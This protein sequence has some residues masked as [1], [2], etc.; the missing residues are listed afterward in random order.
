MI[1]HLHKLIFLLPLL[2]LGT[3]CSNLPQVPETTTVEDTALPEYKL[4]LATSKAALFK[5]LS[6]ENILFSDETYPSPFA[7]KAPSDKGAEVSD[8]EDAEQSESASGENLWQRISS[9]YV[10]LP[11]QDKEKFADTLDAYKKYRRYFSDFSKNASPYLHHIVESLEN[12]G[13]PLE[14]ALLP[15]VESAFRP[16][17]RSPYQAEGIWQFI[18]STG[19]MFGLKQ[20]GWY[21]GRRDVMA[22]TD[23]ALDYLEVLHKNLDN[24]WLNA[25]AAYNCGEGNVRRAIN[26]NVAEGKPTDYWSLDLP[27]E[28][29][30]YIPK[31]MAL[32]TIIAKADDYGIS[33]EEIP[34][35]PY[36]STVDVGEQ[37]DLKLAAQLADLPLQELRRLNPGF[38]H[39]VTDP[40]GP[41]SLVLPMDRIE[42][43]RVRLANVDNK[44]PNGQP[45]L[46]S[47][48]E[49][50]GN[51][52][53]SEPK[54]QLKPYKIR[55][56]DNLA[57][58]ARR[59]STT[60][61]KICKLNGIKPKT[62]L[63]A[64]AT[65]ILPDSKGTIAVAQSSKKGS[66][67]TA[68]NPPAGKGANRSAK[69]TVPLPTPASQR[70]NGHVHE[71]R[72]GE[73]LDGIAQRYSTT[74]EAL[75]EL[76]GITRRT[77]LRVGKKLLIP[78][79]QRI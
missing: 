71:I 43:F 49:A 75:C 25:I 51:S 73:A 72:Q 48:K 3:G 36:I 11:Q 63:R 41:F 12:R 40:K 76:N 78:A 20:N 28:T 54:A 21:D 33:L 65:L 19:R 31:L 77:T 47:W 39:D 69:N 8:E 37:I 79:S 70:R 29:K 6:G 44:M 53:K 46:S 55:R 45:N 7:K 26:K 61:E 52:K 10:L 18:P 9:G 62:R 24:N 13:M 64:G 17:A 1:P 22:A 66:E 50:S 68:H 38:K 4:D 58:I 57:A 16:D 35:K 15:A 14:I 59:H 74:V 42:K 32:S 23:A 67:K 60:V 5:P 2:L 30:A 56:G 34:N 27:A